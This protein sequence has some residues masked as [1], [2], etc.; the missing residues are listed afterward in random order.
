MAAF[1]LDRCFTAVAR[2]TAEY[3]DLPGLHLTTAQVARLCGL[4]IHEADVV[5]TALVASGY[6]SCGR[7][8]QYAV[9]NPLAA[10]VDS[11][12]RETRHLE[13]TH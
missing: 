2:L 10:D 4:S 6:L 8:G 13:T 5:L 9:A 12:Q 7:S 1:N 3:R 11:H